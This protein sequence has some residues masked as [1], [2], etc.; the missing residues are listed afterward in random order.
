MTAVEDVDI[1]GIG[2]GGR[3]G[4]QVA[5]QGITSNN[6]VV[7][8]IRRIHFVRGQIGRRAWQKGASF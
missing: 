4:V 3:E 8:T 5:L 1:M 6:L 2:R 7:D